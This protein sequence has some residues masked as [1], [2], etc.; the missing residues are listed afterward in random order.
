MKYIVKQS[1]LILFVLVLAGC[2]E[3]AKQAEAIK[4]TAQLT[5]I[6]LANINFEQAD[7]IFDLEIENKN[8]VA[9]PVTGVEY[10]LKIENQTLVSGV[11]TQALNIKPASTSTV[12]LPVTVK[13]NDLGKLSGE[14][15]NKDRIVYRLDTQFIVDLPVIG[16]Y[17]VP[18]SKQGELPVPKI[19]DI[20]IKNMKIKNLSLKT[21]ELVATVEVDNPNDFALGLSDFD[22][23]LNINQQ[24]WGRGNVQKINSIPKKARGTIDIPV[25]LDLLAA[26]QSVYK[27][28]LN[29]LPLQYQ[30]TGGINLDTGIE[31]LRN[32]KIPLDINGKAELN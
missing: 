12:Q 16:N 24:T 17:A 11:T 25:K 5:D 32:Y 19:P 22:Y 3:L 30:L 10:D 15:R 13:F 23:Q 6:H 14:L 4:P 7:M 21:A 1:I 20:N 29:K 26:G 27:A 2:A 9:L 18:V 8:P 28:L 31:L